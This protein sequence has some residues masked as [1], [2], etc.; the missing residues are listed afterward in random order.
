M[1][2]PLHEFELLLVRFRQAW[3]E[4][5]A[6]RASRPD[7]QR[8]PGA[9][10]KPALGSVNEML[11]FILVYVRQYPTQDLMGVL[12]GR[13]QS[14]VCEWVHRL[15]PLLQ[16]AMGK[17]DLLPLRD[18][19]ASLD[20]LLR[21]C[22]EL[23]FI[24][25]GTERPVQRPQDEP[26]QRETYSGKK[27]RHTVKNIIVTRKTTKE[28]VFTGKTLPGSTHDKRA[29]DESR[30]KFPR[31]SLVFQDTGFQGH[32]PPGVEVIQPKKK[33]IGHEL[34]EEEKTRN[35]EISRERI[36][37]EHSIGGVKVFR[38]VRDVFRNRRLGCDDLVME[39]ACGLHNHRMRHM[40]KAA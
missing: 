5:E 35:R 28:V 24:L 14:W 11:V 17:E 1:G 36:G 4:A 16:Q 9:G 27:K 26:K 37:V 21:R 6:E 19:T 33:P 10:R 29:V 18:A 22:P 25:D 3:L 34:S 40:K 7:R 2:M 31:G 12:C 23:E 30:L 13:S 15:L 38:I 39:I 20:S 32:A 8:A